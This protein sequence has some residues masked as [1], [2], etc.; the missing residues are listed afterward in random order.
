MNVIV[1]TDINVL[2]GDLSHDCKPEGVKRKKPVPLI[3][4]LSN[5]TGYLMHEYVDIHHLDV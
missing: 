5:Q 4:R 1:Q 3:L 2:L